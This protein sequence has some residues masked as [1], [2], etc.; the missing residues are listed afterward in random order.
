MKLSKSLALWMMALLFATVTATTP[1]HAAAITPDGRQELVALYLTMFGRAPTTVQLAQMV[2]ARENGQTLVQVA[3]TLSAETDFALVASK[4]AD[5]FATYL[6]DTLLSSDTPAAARD[7]SIN[8]A[9]TQIQGTKTKAQVIAEAVQAV[10]SSTG[11]NYTSSKAKLAADVTAALTSIDNPTPQP[12]AT[13]TGQQTSTSNPPSSSLEDILKDLGELTEDMKIEEE[14]NSGDYRSAKA[15]IDAQDEKDDKNKTLKDKASTPSALD[16]EVQALKDSLKA[17][18]SDANRK[19]V[20]EA[21]VTLQA[22]T[23]I[24]TANFGGNWASGGTGSEHTLQMKENLKAINDR[25]T[26]SIQNTIRG[27]TTCR[28]VYDSG[29]HTYVT[30]CSSS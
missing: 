21:I 9:V 6:A 29:S 26:T 2:V 27:A 16:K 28:T 23:A 22:K 25:V 15:R 8:W 19:K 30:R 10:R 7:Q 14:D 12:A 13:S 1:A 18:G 5:S 4:D 20:A 17:D 3:T 24:W 11:T